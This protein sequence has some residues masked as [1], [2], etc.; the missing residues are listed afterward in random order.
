MKTPKMRRSTTAAL[1]ERGYMQAA[2]ISAAGIGDQFRPAAIELG[3]Q[4]A[5]IPDL[6]QI[7]EGDIGLLGVQRR[8]VLMVAFRGI[9]RRQRL[10][11]GHDRAGE[12][13]CRVELRDIGRRDFPLMLV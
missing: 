10:Y 1:N 8:I 12:N 7:V 11:A 3:K 4:M 6:G 2:S 13:L 9:E 5:Q